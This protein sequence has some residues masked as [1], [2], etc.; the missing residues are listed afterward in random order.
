MA[1]DLDKQYKTDPELEENGV[2]EEVGDGARLLI[3]RIN[4]PTYVRAYRQIPRGIRRRFEAGELADDRSDDIICDILSK[5]VLLNF[6]NLSIGD[7][8]LKYSQEA[9]RKVLKKYPDFRELVWQIANEAQRFH[10]DSVEE[11][12]KNSP[13]SSGGS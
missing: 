4:N 2:W 12:A 8:P 11:D 9:A 10:G 3:A 13:S 5:T 7:K 6:E 1:L